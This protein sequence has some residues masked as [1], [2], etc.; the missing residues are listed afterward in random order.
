MVKSIRA[1]VDTN[2]LH[3]GLYSSK[4][5]SHRILRQIEA[6]RLVPVLSTSL[7][8]E[9]EEVLVRHRVQLGLTSRDIDDVLDGLC[10]QGEGR[11]VHFLWRPQLPDAK[12]D[13]VLELA[14]A[15]GCVPVV[16]HNARDFGPARLFGVRIASPGAMLKELK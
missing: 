16:T 12:D 13:H 8:Y 1:V 4:G 14:V 6:G 2:V 9:Y 15:A 11:R 5:A 3:A 10:R 7:L